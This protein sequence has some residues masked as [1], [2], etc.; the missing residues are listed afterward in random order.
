MDRPTGLAQLGAPEAG[1]GTE[2]GQGGAAP[3][4]MIDQAEAARAERR[5]GEE[6]MRRFIAD[7]GHEPRT[8]LAS[9]AGCAEP[10]SRLA[11]D[12]VRHRITAGSARMTG[13]VEDLL[14]LARLDAGRSLHGAEVDLAAVVAEAVADPRTRG[15]DHVRRRQLQVESAVLTVGDHP[16]LK[17]AVTAPLVN[18]RVHT[19]PGTTVTVALET[20]AGRHTVRV[21][22]TAR[23]SARPAPRGLRPR[24]PRRSLP[25]LHGPRRGRLGTGPRRG[26]PGTGPRGGGG[27]HRGAPGSYRRP[28]RAG[29]HRFRI[30]LP[31]AEALPGEP[32]VPYGSACSA[33]ITL[34]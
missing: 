33:Q 26:R 12:A 2:A 28:Q 32:A 20:T 6:R 8:P 22:T 30:G 15:A 31:V 11:P 16:H 29:P 4:R 27:D 1:P 7:A 13:L 25:H 34:P 21:A 9:L 18:A 5:R 17:Q 14:L 24:H 23:V 19:P 10:M 3:D